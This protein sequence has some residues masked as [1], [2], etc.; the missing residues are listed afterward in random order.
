MNHYM[1]PE[2]LINDLFPNKF[3]IDPLNQTFLYSQF[4]KGK[5]IKNFFLVQNGPK[6]S[7]KVKRTK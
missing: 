6:M 4:F 1:I 5:N 7:P 2:A 3:A